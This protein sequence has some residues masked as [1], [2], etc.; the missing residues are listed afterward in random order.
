MRSFFGLFRPT[1][2]QP[3]PRLAQ[4][5]EK[6]ERELRTV[7]A[8]VEAARQRLEREINRQNDIDDLTSRVIPART[9]R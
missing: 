5:M 9:N 8:K 2:P 6:S 1:P 3:D 7:R 4:A